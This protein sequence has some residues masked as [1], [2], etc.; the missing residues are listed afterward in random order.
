MNDLCVGYGLRSHETNP[1]FDVVL[2]WYSRDLTH[3]II[4]D[5]EEKRT[6]TQ[7]LT[8]G[9]WTSSV[10]CGRA[11]EVVNGTGNNRTTFS[12]AALLS[13][14]GKPGHS[15]Q[16]LCGMRNSSSEYNIGNSRNAGKPLPQ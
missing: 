1:L 15:M 4:L 13:N 2:I 11:Q 8:C 7:R 5:R 9:V 12:R 14:T 16:I 10:C 6:D 3:D